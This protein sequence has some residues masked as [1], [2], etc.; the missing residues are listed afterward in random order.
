MKYIT[1]AECIQTSFRIWV[2]PQDRQ[3][4]RLSTCLPRL[5]S[6]RV[7]WPRSCA[8]NGVQANPEASSF[9]DIISRLPGPYMYPAYPAAHYLG[10]LHV[11]G[12]RAHP[13]HG[14]KSHL[15]EIP[16]LQLIHPTLMGLIKQPSACVSWEHL[17]TLF[18]NMFPL[19]R[20]KEGRPADA[21]GR[22]DICSGHSAFICIR[23]PPRAAHRKLWDS[24]ARS[25]GARPMFP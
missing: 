18:Q 23:C 3:R 16:R 17:G 7:C 25:C 11:P 19:D 20:K 15:W 1:A 2:P 12:G 24:L 10:T 4:P 14:H 21:L 8:D 9:E 6:S 22:P 13:W 5:E